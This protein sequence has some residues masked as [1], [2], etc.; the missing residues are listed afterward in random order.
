MV[1]PVQTAARDFFYLQEAQTDSGAHTSSYSE[2]TGVNAVADN[3]SSSSVEVKSDWSHTFMT[4]KGRR[5]LYTTLCYPHQGTLHR[6]LMYLFR[7]HKIY[8]VRIMTRRF[9]P[10]DTAAMANVNNIKYTF[11]LKSVYSK[12]KCYLQFALESDPGVLPV[13]N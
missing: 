1:V 4:A 6:W 2:G 12:A 3:S 10:V 11:L 13:I 7:Q 9:S 5:L 8:V